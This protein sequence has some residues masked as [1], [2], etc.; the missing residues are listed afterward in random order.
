MHI[1]NILHA[2]FQNITPSQKFG[3]DNRLPDRFSL[4]LDDSIKE[5][6]V[7]LEASCF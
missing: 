3:Q 2:I 7:G 4:S 1:A 5:K 6:R